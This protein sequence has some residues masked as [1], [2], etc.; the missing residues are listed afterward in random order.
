MLAC[1]Q[2]V[3]VSRR[4]AGQV[5]RVRPLRLCENS[6]WDRVWGLRTSSAPGFTQRRQGGV[7]RRRV[8]CCRCASTCRAK[9]PSTRF[10]ELGHQQ[11]WVDGL[12]RG[13]R[14][15]RC[16]SL[17]P[18]RARLSA[19]R[20]G[21]PA[22]GWAGGSSQTLA[23]LRELAAGQGLGLEDVFGSGFHAK[24]PRRC[25]AVESVLLPMRVNV[26]RKDAKR[27]VFRASP[28]KRQGS[29]S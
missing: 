6:L 8:C 17:A 29:G 13:L 12:E 3:A 19:V 11:A 7:G 20:R 18:L 26:S 1:R 27:E 28:P 25:G 2:C 22:F 21:Q 24:T 16:W 23:S 5:A 9:T 14:L 4:S 10:S 15:V